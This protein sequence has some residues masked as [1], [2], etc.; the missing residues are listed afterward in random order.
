MPCPKS[1]FQWNRSELY[2]LNYL[3]RSLITVSFFGCVHAQKD[4]QIPDSKS[5]AEMIAQLFKPNFED[6][7]NTIKDLQQM[8]FESNNINKA[9]YLISRLA[10]TQIE[11]PTRK[12]ETVGSFLQWEEVAKSQQSPIRWQMLRFEKRSRASMVAAYALQLFEED[13]GHS[14]V[15]LLELTK[16]KPIVAYL[17]VFLIQAAYSHLNLK[18][19][20]YYFPNVLPEKERLIIQKLFQDTS[21]LSWTKTLPSNMKQFSGMTH[22]ISGLY[23]WISYP[24]YKESV[25]FSDISKNADAYYDLG[26]GFATP[27][28][29]RIFEKKFSSFD[30]LSP[31]K[32]LDWNVVIQVLEAW[33]LPNFGINKTRIQTESERQ[34]YLK[35]VNAVPFVY[36]DV[37]A[38][39]FPTAAQ[40]YVITSFGFLSSTVGSESV[41]SKT[42]PGGNGYFSLTYNATK[43]IVELIALGKSVD[44]FTY[45]RASEKDYRYRTMLLSFKDHRLVK[46]KLYPDSEIKIDKTKRILKR[47]LNSSENI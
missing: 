47:T 19:E 1:K 42:S 28:V 43:R 34:I 17:D 25:G 13:F 9:S 26:G 20:N 44:L 8:V 32:A 21:I 5:D 39:H 36:F 12:P 46:A 30:I 31:Q 6:G 4:I 16:F 27:D 10:T 22:T 37:F 11:K 15:V 18:L 40:S 7:H 23:D 38:D 35:K 45:Q 14:R 29:D 33:G 41:A 2:F 24:E 3:L